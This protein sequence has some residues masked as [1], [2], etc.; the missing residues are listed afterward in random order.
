MNKTEDDEFDA[1]PITQEEMDKISQRLSNKGFVQRAP[2]DI[3]QQEKT[4]Y[5]NL[6]NDIKKIS[7][8]IESL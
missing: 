8:T 2:K 7:L 6:K 5:S 4:N 3:V 1:E